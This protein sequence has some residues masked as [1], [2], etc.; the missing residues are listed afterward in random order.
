[1]RILF[2]GDE[3]PYSEYALKETIKLAMNTWA[4]VTLLGVSQATN[5]AEDA[6]VGKAL[7]G[8][9]DTF[10]NSW[11]RSY[12]ILQ[13]IRRIFTAP[14]IEERISISLRAFPTWASSAG[15]VA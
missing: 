2:A 12:L 5:P 11:S 3:H 8:Y 7:R 9:R 13:Y 10:L 1:M 4:D 14:T 6:H 15:F